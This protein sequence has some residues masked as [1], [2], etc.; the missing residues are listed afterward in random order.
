MDV[1]SGRE[2][3]DGFSEMGSHADTTIAG[4]NMVMLDDLADVLHF[5][6]VSPFS[7]DYAPIKKVPIAQCATAWTDPESGVVWILVFDEALY[8][9]DKV[10]NSLINPNQIRS[11][12][13]NKVDD[14]PR[15]FDPNSNHGI[16]FVSDVDDK[17]LFIP[18]HMDGVISY[19]ALMSAIM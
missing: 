9:G 7:D 18:L 4:S 5:V 3:I 19:F 1:D 10:R 13:F 2:G 14:T 12:A 6:N 16:T 17:T 15:Q 8:F 11:H